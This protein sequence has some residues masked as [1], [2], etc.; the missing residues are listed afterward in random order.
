MRR[1]LGHGLGFRVLEF[2]VLGLCRVLGFCKGLI[3]IGI[4]VCDD[5]YCCCDYKRGVD[6][7]VRFCGACAHA[8]A[9]VCVFL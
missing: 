8:R 5:D 7:R 1:E 9:C 2:W 4:I 6:S 3:D